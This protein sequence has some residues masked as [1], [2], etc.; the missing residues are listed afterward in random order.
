M[1]VIKLNLGCGDKKLAG[2][3]NVDTCCDPDQRYDL[4]QFPWPW[5]DNSIDEVFASHFLEHVVN[6]ERTILEI[7]RILKPNAVFHFLVP[8]YRSPLAQWHLHHWQFS[9]YTPEL[10]CQ[11]RPY[12]WGGCQLFVKERIRANY[13]AIRHCVALPLGFIAN[14]FPF[15]WDWAGLPITEVEFRGRK[16]AE[17][18]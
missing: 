6:Y 11:K 9:I 15:F 12:Q 3:L 4:S 14:V 5:A 8:H 18:Q 7:H 10:L 1:D 16:V 13:P 2:Y 17:V